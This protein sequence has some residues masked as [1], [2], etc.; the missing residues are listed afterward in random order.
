LP[1]FNKQQ[2]K[3]MKKTLFLALAFLA[4]AFL[5]LQLNAQ[6]SDTLKVPKV[7][8]TLKDGLDNE[9]QYIGAVL[10]H[11]EIKERF[12][13]NYTDT[14]KS[15]IKY[16]NL[17]LNLSMKQKYS[18]KIYPKKDLLITMF[19]ENELSIEILASSKNDF[20]VET[21]KKYKVFLK[22]KENGT[23]ELLKIWD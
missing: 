21:I 4:L 7:I 9:V 11:K 14:L 1:L 23:F 2:K 3:K 20:G 6:T 10:S 12:G 18:Y 19:N 15:A 8:E 13:E 5:A 16:A 17:M 22:P